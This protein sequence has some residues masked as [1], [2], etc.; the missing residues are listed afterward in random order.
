MLTVIRLVYQ[1]LNRNFTCQMPD[2]F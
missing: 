1:L 2:H